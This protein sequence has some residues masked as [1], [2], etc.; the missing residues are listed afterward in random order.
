MRFDVLKSQS[1]I[2]SSL[3]KAAHKYGLLPSKYKGISR[4][5]FDE[6]LSFYL[7][8]KSFAA[9]KTNPNDP[10]RV[11]TLEG[12]ESLSK[13]YQRNNPEISDSDL[14]LCV[15]LFN[16]ICIKVL[17]CRVQIGTLLF[18]LQ[19]YLLDAI[20]D[21]KLVSP[22]ET[23]IGKP[24]YQLSAKAIYDS[25]LDGNW[26]KILT[27]PIAHNFIKLCDEDFDVLI[28]INKCFDKKLDVNK[29]LAFHLIWNENFNRDIEPSHWFFLND[30]IESQR[31][32]VKTFETFQAVVN[33]VF[34]S[35]SQGAK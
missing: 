33:P 32:N 2:L 8:A 10:S 26:F 6:V 5:Q 7:G 35:K 19:P 18:P 31:K 15:H 21:I 20:S 16:E 4:Q 28:D 22:D 3:N 23:L 25:A 1:N 17:F 29:Q 13:F 12:Q 30:Y 11:G 27:L 14:Q 34:S 9:I 24:A